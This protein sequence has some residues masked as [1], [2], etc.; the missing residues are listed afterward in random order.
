M[1]GGGNSLTG[2]LNVCLDGGLVQYYDPGGYLSNVDGCNGIYWDHVPRNEPCYAYIDFGVNYF[3]STFMIKWEQDLQLI[4][5]YGNASTLSVSNVA[6]QSSKE[7][8][9]STEGMW[10]KTFENLS[11]VLWRPRDEGLNNEVSKYSLASFSTNTPRLWM[12]FIRYPVNTLTVQWWTDSD[13][14]SKYISDAV[15]TC[16]SFDKFRYLYIFQNYDSSPDGE[17]DTHT[18]Y[19]F[20]FEVISPYNP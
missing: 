5:N 15:I 3:G 9:A 20:N 16:D 2:I 6:D 19:G 8:E 18:G 1:G 11:K 10:F 12:N 4:A 13:R 17:T 14:T 7:L